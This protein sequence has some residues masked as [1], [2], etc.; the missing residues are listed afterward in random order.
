MCDNI[1]VFP[2]QLMTVDHCREISFQEGLFCKCILIRGKKITNK[3]WKCLCWWQSGTV[4]MPHHPVS[5]V[6]KNTAAHLS[7]SEG[8]DFFQKC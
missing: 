5:I 2:S 7:F 4:V 1:C 6:A 3:L 8:S